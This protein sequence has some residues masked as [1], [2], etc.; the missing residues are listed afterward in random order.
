MSQDRNA[1][2]II[3]FLKKQDWPCTTEDI[4]K[5]TKLAWQTAQIH[6]FRLAHQGKVKHKKVGRQNQW[7]LESKYRKEF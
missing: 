7:W 4:A 5:G 6:L 2:V 1:K 3:D